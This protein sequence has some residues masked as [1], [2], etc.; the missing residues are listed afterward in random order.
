MDADTD[1]MRSRRIN[2]RLTEPEHTVLSMRARAAGYGELGPYIRVLAM[3]NQ[4]PQDRKVPQVNYATWGS[5]GKLASNLN[6]LLVYLNKGEVIDREQG[7][8]LAQV[9]ET[10]RRELADVRLL[11]LGATEQD[12]D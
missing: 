10:L 12:L 4:A 1:T 6:Q 9:L 11:L 2:I 5:L 8:Q 7:E 3:R